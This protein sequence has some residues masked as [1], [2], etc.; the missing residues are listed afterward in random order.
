MDRAICSSSNLLMSDYAAMNRQYNRQYRAQSFPLTSSGP[1]HG[2]GTLWRG[3]ETE[4][5]S[6]E[7]SCVRSR[8]RA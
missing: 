1:R 3:D 8:Q 6:L 2:P 4:S 5:S 7:Y